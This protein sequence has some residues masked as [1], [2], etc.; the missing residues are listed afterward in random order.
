M[1]IGHWAPALAAA[2]H[3]KAP[4]PWVL[5]L[6]AQLVDVAFFLFVLLGVEHMRIEP[7]ATVMNPMDLYDMPYT[8]SLLGGLVWALVLALPVWWIMKDR[9]AALLAGGVVMSHWLLDW[10]VHR[11]DLTIAGSPPKLGLGL[12]N[13]PAIEMPLE[14]GITALALWWY[15]RRSKGPALP[16]VVLA[17]V[18]LGLQAINWFGPPPTEL[19]AELPVSA[20]LA[21]AIGIA[22]A[23]WLGTRRELRAREG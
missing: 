20:L 15:V 16:A 6:A 21:Y 8:H 3:P 10:L 11:P 23:W 17:L 18:M 1:F 7:G 4:K 2:S 19:T 13:F 9:F 22:A 14:L 5:F 12:W